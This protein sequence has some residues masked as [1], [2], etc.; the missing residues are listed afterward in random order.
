MRIIFD[1]NIWISFLIGKKLSQLESILRDPKIIVCY[2]HELEQEFLEVAHR[3]KIREY[4][5]EK[6]I[7][8]TH[9][10]MTKCCRFEIINKKDIPVRDPKDAYLLE[11]SDVAKA[12]LLITGDS[13]LLEIKNYCKTKIVCFAEAI[14]LI[15]Q[16]LIKASPE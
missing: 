9:G 1:T 8:R 6:S 4:V 3:V 15:K 14:I 10:L 7:K 11:L 13:D 2:C 16:T 5:D 12:E